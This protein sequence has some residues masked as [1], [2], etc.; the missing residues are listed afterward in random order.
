MSNEP[1]IEVFMD[2]VLKQTIT[3]DSEGREK[4]EENKLR[5]LLK[6]NN[7]FGGTNK[8]KFYDV[9]ER[10]ETCSDYSP[11]RICYKC[12]NKASHL[13]VKCSNC[14]I[15]ACIHTG[16]NV[17][18]MIKRKNFALKVSS[19]TLCKIKKMIKEQGGDIDGI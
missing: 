12:T 14:N 6:Q 7:Q 8:Q 9:E 13:H 11:C 16:A 10:F 4:F 5:K 1:K 15:P 18:K 3:K 17:N 19:D 2:G